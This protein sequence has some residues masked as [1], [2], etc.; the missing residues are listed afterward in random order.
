[1]GHG[2]SLDRPHDRS[3]SA[4]VSDRVAITPVRRVDRGHSETDQDL[5]AVEAPVRLS[6][7]QAGASLQRSLGVVLRTPGHD[8]DLVLGLLFAEGL[9]RTASDVEAIDIEDAPA[10]TDS[11]GPALVVR[12][13]P[14]IDLS[15]FQADRALTSTTSCGFC[16]RLRLRDIE[17]FDNGQRARESAPIAPSVIWTLPAALSAG[18]T[19]FAKTGGLHA[20]GL[21]D[22]QGVLLAIREDVGRHN[23]LDKLVGSL[24]DR[25]ALPVGDALVVVSGRVAFE[26]V[27]KTAAA[28]VSVLVAVGAP[29]SL[30][31]E[32]A[33]MSGMTLIGFARDERFNVYTRPER[34]GAP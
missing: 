17:T 28:G 4:R 9:I 16:G 29:S 12:L 19:I 30:A 25:Q 24:L 32:A 11:P 13:A 6:I 2:P 15:T 1:M 7:V 14:D 27:Q 31:V 33:R 26:I 8:R 21:F 34:V 18:Q 22:R 23:A 20:A 5:V 3:E 10:E